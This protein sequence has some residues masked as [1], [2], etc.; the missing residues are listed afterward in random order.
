[1]ESNTFNLEPILVI[2][3]FCAH[4]D[5]RRLLRKSRIPVKND[6][7]GESSEYTNI[8]STL[9]HRKLLQIAADI[10]NGMQHL[11]AHEVLVLKIC[12]S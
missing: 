2:T 8:F 10:A 6:S 4:G 1:M 12:Y 11:A 5:L 9:C 3:E 7:S